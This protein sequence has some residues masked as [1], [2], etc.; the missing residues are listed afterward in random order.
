MKSMNPFNRES[1]ERLSRVQA[2]PS[3][4]T[5]LRLEAWNAF[6][7]LSKEE[8][9]VALDSIQAFAEPPRAL[10]PVKTGPKI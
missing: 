1:I 3:W 2:E 10:Y 7:R 4:M 5:T 8:P 6:E 9:V